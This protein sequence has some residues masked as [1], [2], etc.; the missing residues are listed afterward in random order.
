MVETL[1][2]WVSKQVRDKRDEDQAEI[3]KC[4]FISCLNPNFMQ[5]YDD[6]DNFVTPI[7]DWRMR[8]IINDFTRELNEDEYSFVKEKF[9][10]HASTLP[11]FMEQGEETN[12]KH[13]Y[14][15][16]FAFSSLLFHKTQKVYAIRGEGAF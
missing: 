5:S 9:L 2:R 14:F 1:R 15:A 11:Q 4:I 12:F 10:L 16:L 8:V 7:Y 13:K 3:P 6:N